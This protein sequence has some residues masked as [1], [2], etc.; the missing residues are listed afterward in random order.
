MNDLNEIRMC[1]DTE[2]LIKLLANSKNPTDMAL[3]ILA[4]KIDGIEERMKDLDKATECARWI[5][6]NK[7]SIISVALALFIFSTFGLAKFMEF[8]KVKIGI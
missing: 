1:K 2:R 4:N 7:K 3:I 6:K 8:I 5:D